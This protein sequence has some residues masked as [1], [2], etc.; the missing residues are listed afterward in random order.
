MKCCIC[1]CNIT[2]FM[3]IPSIMEFHILKNKSCGPTSYSETP[4]L[5]FRVCMYVRDVK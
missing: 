5:V 4:D 2:L 3:F 1:V